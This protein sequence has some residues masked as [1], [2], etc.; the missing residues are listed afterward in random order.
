[1]ESLAETPTQPTR[2]RQFYKDAYTKTRAELKEADKKHQ[3]ALRLKAE[4]CQKHMDELSGSRETAHQLQKICDEV[5]T[6]PGKVK[7]L[8]QALKAA[9]AESRASRLAHRERVRVL[10]ERCQCCR[11]T[12]ISLMESLVDDAGLSPVLAAARKVE[13]LNTAMADVA[14]FLGKNVQTMV[15]EIFQEEIE[16]SYENCE[17]TIGSVLASFIYARTQQGSTATPDCLIVNVVAHIFILSFCVSRL[18][19]CSIVDAV[20]ET[21][22]EWLFDLKY[23]LL[24][25]I[26]CMKRINLGRRSS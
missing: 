3:A 7:K 24:M 4:E 13:A 16:R 17:R 8:E 18:N 6:L 21:I 2:D 23:A 22:G 25:L 19:H 1:M 14:F 5:T 12:H 10:E 9:K 11:K 26:T 15:H 20:G